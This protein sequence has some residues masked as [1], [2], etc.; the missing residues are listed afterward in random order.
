[1]TSFRTLIRNTVRKSAPNGPGP[2]SQVKRVAVASVPVLMLTLGVPFVNRVEPRILG[3][4]F[5]LA[6]ILFWIV[7]TPGFMAVVY[8]LDRTK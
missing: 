2:A 8:R 5:V 3:L 4:P 1:M 6:W 7:C